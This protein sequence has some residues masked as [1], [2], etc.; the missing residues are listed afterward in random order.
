MALVGM[1]R[2]SPFFTFASASRIAGTESRMSF[3]R[4]DGA[5]TTMTAMLNAGSDCWKER[6]RSTVKN[7]SK[8]GAA[9]A[10]NCPFEYAAQPISGTVFTSCPMSSRRS[11]RGTHS[12]RRIFTSGGG[13][14]SVPGLFEKCDRLF[15]SYGREIIKKFVKCFSA[16]DVVDECLHGHAGACKARRA[17]HNGGVGDN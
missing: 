13:Q 6:L 14:H 4:F 1:R 7:T 10:S 12:S 5:A 3:N 8:T 11:L 15:P 16:F 2:A 17:S 9:S